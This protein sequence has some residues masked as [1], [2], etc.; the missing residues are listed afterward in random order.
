MTVIA[1]HKGRPMA[2]KIDLGPE[3]DKQAEALRAGVEQLTTLRAQLVETLQR[4]GKGAGM[5][6]EQLW[7]WEGP[8]WTT[9]PEEWPPIPKLL[10][11]WD[12][13]VTLQ[14]AVN[15]LRHMPGHPLYCDGCSGA[16]KFPGQPWVK[17][18]CPEHVDIRA[19]VETI[20]KD[21]GFIE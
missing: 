4:F 11:L 1:R 18:R 14:V 20:A 12:R 16:E 13:I 21:L 19:G 7:G 3:V 5:W 9:T 17:W 10:W 6:A 15:G 2:T 8:N